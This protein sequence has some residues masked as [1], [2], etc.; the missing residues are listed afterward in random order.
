MNKLIENKVVRID[1][2]LAKEYGVKVF[3]KGKDPLTELIF[4]TLSQ[5]TNDLNRDRAFESLK[6]S[7]PTW[8]DAANTTPTKLMSAIKVGGLAKIKAA[9]ILKML[10]SIKKSHGKIDLDFLHKL[11]DDQVRD[12]L[13]KIE[14][15]G[16]KTVACVLAF[17]LGRDVMPVDTHVRRVSARLG[18]LPEKLSDLAAHEY[19]LQ[20][21]GLV[22]LYQLHLNLINHGRKICRARKPVCDNCSFT[23]LCDYFSVNIKTRRQ[24]V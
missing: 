6:Q 24:A 14:G 4:T 17:S 12:Y 16:P 2:I 11:T 3:N 10:R 22:S 20:F 5:N 19:F 8:D 1:K 23:Q 13:I 18:I 15:V 21:K 7:F 9:R